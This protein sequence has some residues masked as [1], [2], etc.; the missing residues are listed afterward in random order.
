MNEASNFCNGYCL[1]SQRPA[2]P[3]KYRLAYTPTGRDLEEKSMPLDAWHPSINRSQLDTHSLFGT[4]QV[5]A[6]HGWFQQEKKRTMII[7]RSSFAGM[8]KFASKWLGDNFSQERY[9]AY[10]VTGVMAMNIAGIPMVGADICGFSLNTTAE[11]CTKWHYVGA[12]YPFSRNHNSI[13]A[14]SQEPYVEMFNVTLK[15]E[16]FLT[17]TLLMRRAI[18]FKYMLIPYYYTE[19][20]HMHEDGGALYKPVYFSFPNELGSY[21][22]PH[23]NVML[24][25]GLKLSI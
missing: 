19:L 16:K 7:E 24:G 25:D 21:I 11:L 15:G 17:Y 2:Q 18:Q 3:E 12:F 8:G 23:N 5:K 13:D 1:D 20:G 6:T 22:E 9:M 14:K 4:T 10:S